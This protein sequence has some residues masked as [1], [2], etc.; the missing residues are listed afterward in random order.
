MPQSLC[1]SFRSTLYSLAL[2][3]PLVL[4]LV[5]AQHWDGPSPYGQNFAPDVKSVD[6]GWNFSYPAFEGNASYPRGTTASDDGFGNE[7][8][9]T[10]TVIARAAKDFYLRILPLGASITEG[11]Q[12]TDGNGYRKWLRLQLRFKGW[13]VNM[14][15]SKQNG[16]MADRVCEPDCWVD[17]KLFKT[18]NHD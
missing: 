7:F 11:S 10:R 2:V 18:S 5:T 14:V 6:A 8:N 4:Q 16:N 1:L 9:Y 13:K 3:L 17:L 12:S 15:G